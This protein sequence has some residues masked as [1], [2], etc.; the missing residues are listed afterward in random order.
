MLMIGKNINNNENSKLKSIASAPFSSLSISYLSLLTALEIP[1][2]ALP[3]YLHSTKPNRTQLRLISTAHRC[4]VCLPG[5]SGPQNRNWLSTSRDMSWVLA[6]PTRVLF[7][8][9]DF[10]Q[11]TC[12]LSDISSCSAGRQGGRWYVSGKNKVNSAS[13]NLRLT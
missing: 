13:L 2:L 11:M 5:F 12:R 4:V 10:V 9:C 1:V 6:A 3:L 7:T 8:P